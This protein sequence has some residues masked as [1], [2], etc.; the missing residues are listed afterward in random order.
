MGNLANK[1]F[2]HTTIA[3]SLLSIIHSLSSCNLNKDVS[4][5]KDMSL[6]AFVISDNDLDDHSDY[7]EHDFA[8]G[9][10]GCP[11]G[12]ELLLYLDRQNEA[13]TLRQ[14]VYSS[15]QIRTKTIKQYEEQC[16]TSPEVFRNILSTMIENSSGRQYGLFYWSHGNGWLPGLNPDLANGSTTRSLGADGTYSMN[17]SDFA[18]ILSET[19]IPLFTVLDACYMGSVEVAY[20]LR[21]STDYLIASSAETLGINFPYHTMIP[22]LVKGTYQAM[23]KS[24]DN[25]LEFCY[26]DYYQDGQIS[27]MASLID[28]S[29]MDS[30][31]SSFKNILKSGTLS[32]EEPDSI[33][34][35]DGPYSHLYYDFG[36]YTATVAE[37]VE[38]IET[39]NE[40]LDRTVVYKVTT[41]SVYNS[42]AFP[43]NMF[44]VKHFS[45]LSVYILGSNSYYDWLYSLTDWYKYCY[46]T[47][48]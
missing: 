8:E 14:F 15:D 39:F 11:D 4:I 2:T 19:K 12:T 13:P 40:Q 25:Y 47:Q 34:S 45:G 37:N 20:E 32:L 33:Q 22:E 17:V 31:A 3:I 10:R 1:H 26:T 21:N 48:E 29:Q 6:F 46:G 36:Q 43:D 35:F 9:L 24:L 7:I 5:N 27:G 41:P 23:I 16:S 44:E 30:L 38:K 18:N 28:C 42:S